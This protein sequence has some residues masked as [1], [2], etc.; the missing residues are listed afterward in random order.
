MNDYMWFTIKIGL[1][2][3]VVMMTL[4]WL[5]AVVRRNAG[6][7]DLGWVLGLMLLAVL[8]AAFGQGYEP[9]KMIVALLVSLWGVRLGGM[10]LRRLLTEEEDKRYQKI[11]ASFGPG[12]NWKFFLFFQ[13][14]GLL[15]VV[16]AIPFFVMCFSSSGRIASLEWL[17]IAVW[18]AGFIG[19]AISD[20]QLKAFKDDPGNR[21]KVCEAGFWYYSRHPNYF[22]EWLIWVGYF[23]MAL[24]APWGWVSVIS[25]LLML[26]FLLNVS[27]VPLAEEQSLR[28]RGDAFREYQ[29]TT[30]V[31][32]PLP[33]RRNVPILE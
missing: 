1:A 18:A 4:L 21:G 16:L 20:A 10:L 19:E 26:H 7:V 23:L 12:A 2:S 25:P 13:F 29:R 24:E 31:F 33:R 27:G 6:W 32:I 8:Y 9:R 3:V 15:D 5:I 22:F 11:R 14:Q 17:G 28:S 30:S